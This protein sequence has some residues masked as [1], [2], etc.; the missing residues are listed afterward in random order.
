MPK[1]LTFNSSNSSSSS[2]NNAEA[3]ALRQ[4]VEEL[5]AQLA[6]QQLLIAG[7]PNAARTASSGI[8]PLDEEHEEVRW[9]G[10]VGSGEMG[11]DTVCGCCGI[12][13]LTTSCQLD[14][15]QTPNYSSATQPGS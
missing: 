13:T 15:T 12:A 14:H 7:P 8:E 4:Q 1:L 6:E 2:N 9:L 10:C 3:E 5:K 11:F